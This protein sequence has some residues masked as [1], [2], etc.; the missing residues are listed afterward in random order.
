[1]DRIG[2]VGVGLMGHGMAANLLAAGHPL[3][4]IAHRNR[5]PVEDLVA[6]GAA[7][8]EDLA[9]LAAASDIVHIC[10]PASPQVEAIV[11]AMIDHLPEG[12]VVIDCSTADPAST[13]TLAARLEECGLA[14]ADAPL[15]GTPVQA[16]AGKLAAMVGAAPETFER[17]CPVIETWA[18]SIVHV[19]GPGAGHKMKLLNNFLAMGYG[20]IYAEALVLA[21][22]AG[23]GRDVFDSVITGSRLDS[24]F[25]QTWR[26]HAIGGDRN[27]HRFTLTNARKDMVYLAAMADGA[28]VANPVGAAVKN[29]YAMAVTAGGDGAEDYVPHLFDFVAR[30]NGL[31]PDTR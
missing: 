19:G 3:T 25:W 10:A 29:A 14:M 27:A 21:E 30:A 26:G 20:A 8:A 18:A 9:A 24:G 16:E 13:A 2:F 1:M 11:G 31:D 5:A 6:R 12:A 4:V 28:G 15:G 22:K 23:I 17:I 7:E